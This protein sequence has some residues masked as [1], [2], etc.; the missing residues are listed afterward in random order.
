MA[1]KSLLLCLVTLSLLVALSY[2]IDFDEKD[3]ASEES[4]YDLYERWRSHHTV[5]TNLRT[6]QERFDV[7]KENVR[8]IHEFNKG[9]D[10][11]KLHLNQFGDL[12]ND[13]FVRQYM[14]IAQHDDVVDGDSDHQLNVKAEGDLTVPSSWDWR[15][16]G[17][18]TPVK[19]QGKCG[20]CWAFSSVAAVE[21]INK[22]KTGNLIS[23]SEQQLVDCNTENHGCKGGWMNTA[24]KYIK[25]NGG[26]TTESKYPYKAVDGTCD[27]AKAK[28]HAV[29][30]DGYQNVPANNENALLSAVANQPISVAIDASGSAFQFYKEGVFSGA[31]GTTLNHAV[32]VV[33]YGTTVDG[34]KYWIVKNSWGSNWGEKGYI[35]MKRGIAAKEGLCGI[36][37]AASYPIKISPKPTTPTV[38]KDEL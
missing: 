24:F 1:N 15:L 7:F 3:L 22:I 17:A 29:V 6:K 21:G 13:E 9:D 37:M 2:A 28:Y 26:I 16:K 18:V 38:T 12:T 5:S 35:R 23:L 11:F 8:F 14:G 19:N 20:A 33:G 25:N 32:T 10:P 4:L 34:T 36:A 30:I 31:C 27:T